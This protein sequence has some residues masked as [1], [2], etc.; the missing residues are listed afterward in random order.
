MD[1]IIAT[2]KKIAVPYELT[3][4]EIKR[5]ETEIFCVV[6]NY[7]QRAQRAMDIISR[8]RCN[9]FYADRQLFFD[10]SE[11]LAT[12]CADHLCTCDNIT[13]DDIIF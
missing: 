6:E 9:L 1:K 11:A 12:Y 13:I 4:E 3:I 8:N 10:M 2:D 7:E 5:N